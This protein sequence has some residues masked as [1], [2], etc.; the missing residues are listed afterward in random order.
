ME[1]TQYFELPQW[2][3]DD[4]ILMTDFNEAMAK[5][6][7]GLAGARERACRQAYNWLG[8][9]AALE[10]PPRQKGCF[11]QPARGQALP[12]GVTG[13]VP[14]NGYWW[15]SDSEVE[16]TAAQVL[17]TVTAVQHMT[18]TKGNLAGC[19]PMI[20]TFT[21]QGPGRVNQLRVKGSFSD[22]SGCRG[23][24]QLRLTN[25]TTGE[26]EI[27]TEVSTS[28]DMSVFGASGSGTWFIKCDLPMRGASSYRME[29]TPKEGNW[30]LDLAYDNINVKALAASAAS[31][32][33]TQTIAQAGSQGGS[34]L[35]R[36]TVQGNGGVLALDWGGETLSPLSV[37]SYAGDGGVTVY[38]AE[39][40]KDSP[41]PAGSQVTLRLTATPT[42]GLS[43]LGWGA[44]VL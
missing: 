4:R 12:E 15:V 26:V 32:A 25:T 33:L 14:G 16:T 42:G 30:T 10:T 1:R 7:A 41:V 2:A 9:M 35:V 13:L 5:I 38:E 43:L 8:S 20:L 37:E 19:Q 22:S 3:E 6:E 24:F 31:G 39:F 23:V 17:A 18:L 40:R 36:Y 28:S 11:F 21:L 29:L 34:A 27:D 44:S